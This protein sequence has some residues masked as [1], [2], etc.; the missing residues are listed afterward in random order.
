VTIQET[1]GLA[2]VREPAVRAAEAIL[3]RAKTRWEVGPC[4]GPDGVSSY[5]VVTPGK[6][7]VTISPAGDLGR[8]LVEAEFGFPGAWREPVEDFVVRVS[9]WV[10]NRGFAAGGGKVRPCADRR[11]LGQF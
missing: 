10:E 11:V 8:I 7:R 3:A 2:A 5:R 4:A 1:D 6:V 9:E